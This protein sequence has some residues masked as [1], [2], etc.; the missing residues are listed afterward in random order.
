MPGHVVS[1]I[2][3]SRGPEDMEVTLFDTLSY[4]VVS[5]IECSGALLFD[6]FGD[7]PAGGRVVCLNGGWVLFVTHF[8]EDVMD[9]SAFFAVDKEG[10]EF[11]FGGSR[12]NV[13][14]DSRGIK[15]G[16]VE[17]GRLVWLI[18]KIKVPS[19]TTV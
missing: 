16:S 12:C 5:H 8:G 14:E 10:A 11:G 1:K 6:S 9:D 17:D 7:D 4:P 2:T 13:F 15:N 18:A 19:G 3:L